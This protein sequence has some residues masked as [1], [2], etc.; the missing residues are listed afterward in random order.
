LLASADGNGVIELTNRQALYSDAYGPIRAK[1]VSYDDMQGFLADFHRN[2]LLFIWEENAKQYGWFVGSD[3]NHRLP[4]PSQWDHSHMHNVLP[5]AGVGKTIKSL[6][7]LHALP[8]HQEFKRAVR[9]Y[10]DECVRQLASTQ[11]VIF[12]PEAA[13]A[14]QLPEAVP[15]ETEVEVATDPFHEIVPPGLFLSFKNMRREAGRPVTDDAVEIYKRRCIEWHKEGRNVIKMI[16]DAIAKHWLDIYPETENGN[17]NGNGR[18]AFSKRHSR[19]DEA[20]VKQAS[21]LPVPRVCSD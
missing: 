3:E 16:E 17:G 19:F 9:R 8:A 2:G 4:P 6:S 1:S 7:A 10:Q 13:P 20:A 21:R 18:A 11:G 5:F 12:A 15:T 14:P